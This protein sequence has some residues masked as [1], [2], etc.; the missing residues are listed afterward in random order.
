MSFNLQIQ[1]ATNITRDQDGAPISWSAGETIARFRSPIK[2]A[3]YVEIHAAE[4]TNAVCFTG[5]ASMIGR[6]NAFLAGTLKKAGVL[7]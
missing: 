7:K 4:L 6:A 3:E 5:S 2:F 1:N